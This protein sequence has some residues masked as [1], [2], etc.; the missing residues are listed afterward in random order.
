MEVD[1]LEKLYGF[2]EIGLMASSSDED[3]DEKN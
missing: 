1:D 2:G 3:N